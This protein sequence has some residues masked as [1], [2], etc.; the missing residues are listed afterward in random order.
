MDNKKPKKSDTRKTRKTR[1]NSEQVYEELPPSPPT[2]EEPKPEFIQIP[3]EKAI[4]PYRHYPKV[5]KFK[6]DG[7]LLLRD[8]M[9][10]SHIGPK[11]G[12]SHDWFSWHYKTDIFFRTY[13]DE[14]E[15]EVFDKIRQEHA[16]TSFGMHRILNKISMLEYFDEQKDMIQAGKLALEYLTRSG[17]LPKA[18]ELVEADRRLEETH[19]RLIELY[20]KYGRNQYGEIT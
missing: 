14:I 3:Q 11:L 20:K 2:T 7:L 9:T 10:K 16:P 19:A 8:G 18:V 6:E 4:V 5:P 12:K 17:R 13:A 1:I 15:N